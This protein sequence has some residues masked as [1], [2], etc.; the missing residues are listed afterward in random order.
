MNNTKLE[1]LS[2]EKQNVVRGTCLQGVNPA[3]G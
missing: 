2:Q 3:F 1:T